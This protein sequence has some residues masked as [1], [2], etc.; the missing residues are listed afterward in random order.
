M[1]EGPW[2][3]D[4]HLIDAAREGKLRATA[5]SGPD[6]CWV[7]A[8]LTAAGVTAEE[9]ARLLHCSLRLVRQIR[10]EP[11]TA[12]C[13]YAL[14]IAAVLHRQRDTARTERI[15]LRLDAENARMDADRFKAQR[16]ELLDRLAAG[17]TTLDRC[18]S[19]HLMTRYNTYIRGDGRRQ[20]REC[21]RERQHRYR[22][23]RTN[24][25]VSD[26]TAQVNAS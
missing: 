21:H 9:T 26:S 12:V 22:T 13:T 10:A 7:V 11:M 2:A 1:T 24:R 8:G 3:P 16:D 23:E 19:G 20:C 15:A 4:E 14:D 6:R 18:R 17:D 25:A 5:M